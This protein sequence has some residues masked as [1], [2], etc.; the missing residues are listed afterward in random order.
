VN[1]LQAVIGNRGF[2]D[3]LEHMLHQGPGG[4]IVFD[5]KNIQGGCWFF[6][7]FSGFRIDVWV[8][9]ERMLRSGTGFHCRTGAGPTAGKDVQSTDMLQTL[10]QRFEN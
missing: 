2:P 3:V 5:D 7:H 6:V 9:K 10:V 1:T 8:Q 4:V